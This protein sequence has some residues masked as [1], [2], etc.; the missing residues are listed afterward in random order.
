MTQFA[1]VTDC[2]TRSN[3]FTLVIDSAS[4]IR[5]NN[6]CSWTNLCAFVKDLCVACSPN[7]IQGVS[8]LVDINAGGDFL[9]LCD[10]KSSYKH[11][12]DFGRLRSYKAFFNSRTR[13]RV[14]RVTEPA[15]GWCT[16][17]AG[18]SFALQALFLPPNCSTEHSNHLIGALFNPSVDRRLKRLCPEDL[19]Q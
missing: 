12:S 16:Q 2:C 15:G 14:K 1:F 11:V 6:S 17:L 18:L 8:R 13:P 4:Y 10:Q 7:Y 3:K 9:G 5:T 19:A